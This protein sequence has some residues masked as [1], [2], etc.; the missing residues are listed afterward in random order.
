[1][2]SYK[3]HVSFNYDEIFLHKRA[4]GHFGTLHFE[5]TRES[6]FV[7]TTTFFAG[8]SRFENK[9][10]FKFGEESIYKSER[11]FDWAN[12]FCLSF[13]RNLYESDV[14]QVSGETPGKCKVI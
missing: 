12:Q 13:D 14:G 6:K 3:F 2:I 5:Q 1:M 9:S 10:S 7:C 8:H 4:L 11:C